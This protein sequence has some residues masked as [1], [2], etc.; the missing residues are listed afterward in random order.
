MHTAQRLRKTRKAVLSHPGLWFLFLGVSLC[1]L[2]FSA[3]AQKAPAKAAARA[4]GVDLS[5]TLD[6]LVEKSIAAD[7]IP[8]AVL[9]VSHQG[10]IIHRKAYGSRALLPQREAMT[11]DTIFDLASLTKVIATMP[12]VMKLVE[13]GKVR[14]NDPV[15]KYLPEFAAGKQEGKDQVT[16]RHLLT[17]TSGLAPIPRGI[18]APGEP[19]QVLAAIDADT[20]VSPPGARFLYSD[21]GFILLGE[22]VRRV[23]GIPLEEFVAQEVFRPLGMRHTRFHPPAEWTPRIAPTEEIDLPEGAKAGSGKG[24]VLRGT[25]HDPRARS[26][27]GVAGNAGLFSTADEL[28]VYCRML[29]SGGRAANGKRIFAAA[30]VR[31]MTTPQT[32][33]WSPTV[34]GLGWDIDSIYS[35]PRGELFPVGTFG[36]TGF[37]GTAVWLDPAS[38]TFIIL[39]ANSV[40]P[41]GRPPISRL[42]SRVATAVATALQKDG[43]LPR[44]RS[45]QVQPAAAPTETSLLERRAGAVG[46]EPARNA[47]TK[48]GL[49]VLAEEN[50]TS[51]RGKRVGLITNHTGMD[52]NGRSAIDLLAHAEGV[53]LVALFSPEHGIAGRADDKVSSSADPTTGLPIYSLYSETRRPTDEML[54]G[55]DALVF[56]I[57]DTGVRFYT[58]ITTMAYA[59]EEAAKRRIAFYVLDRPNPLG[60][61]AIEGPLL[62]RD[63]LNFVGYFPM[64]VRYAMTIGELAQMFNAENKIGCDLHVVAMK[65]WGRRDW[66]DSTGLPWLAPSP[67]LRSL[68]A[69]LLYPGVEI[70]QSADVSVG[71]GTDMPFELLGAPWIRA[72]ELADYLNRRFVPGVRFVPT[73]FTPRASPH[74][75]QPCEGLA[76]LVTDRAS[77]HSMLMGLEIAA[78]LAKLYPDKFDVERL[79]SLVGSKATIARLK[80]GDAP[81]VIVADWSEELDTFKKMRAKYLL[82]P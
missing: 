27:G 24:R 55:I 40:H 71:R 79:L 9:L 80:K 70:L 38:Q 59:M 22:L 31:K 76:L 5:A 72:T 43:R 56:D 11:V 69:A 8:G 19:E 50:F 68:S 32:P 53:K 60:G 64:P 7:E 45:G 18:A 66:Y 2:S 81:S 25:V 26:M 65:D 74:K 78:A 54:R 42:R 47:H 29:L 3:A 58:Y 12:S 6:P 73:R 28:A 16:L 77:F 44:L 33:P 52:R 41:Y 39:L 21:A 13:Q 15:A 37:T 14:L 51:L 49:E 10:R 67:N 61:E 35:A 30:T 48:T 46:R 34:R 1:L 36:H 62:D 17:H 82:Y 75:E 4:R 63:R 57:Q 20:L 23:S